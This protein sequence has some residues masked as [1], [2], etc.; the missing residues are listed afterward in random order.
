MAFWASTSEPVPSTQ[1]AT[2]TV[3]PGTES[4]STVV[5]LTDPG[6]SSNAD[7]HDSNAT[8]PP[9]VT[10]TAS[11]SDMSDS[12]PPG[13]SDSTSGLTTT[14]E[15]DNAVAS[16]V[17]HIQ[18]NNIDYPVEMLR[19]L[20]SVMVEGR[21][22]EIQ[23]VTETLEGDTNLIFVDRGRVLETGLDEV[24]KLGNKRLTLEVQFY[25]EVHIIQMLSDFRIF[26]QMRD[27]H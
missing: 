11:G 10:V 13:I 15:I 2:V 27:R 18:L 7:P 14:S 5:T 19:H 1:Q 21:Q 23:D 20:Q 8:M 9:N 6:N 24:S 22:L 3:E 16:V 17:E 25:G 4:P 12:L 26:M